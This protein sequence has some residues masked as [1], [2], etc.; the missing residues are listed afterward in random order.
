MTQ[1]KSGGACRP[2]VLD[3][4]A[5]HVRPTLGVL[6]CG[7]CL[8][9]PAF[10]L[11]TMGWLCKALR[12]G[13]APCY[14]LKEKRISHICEILDVLYPFGYLRRAYVHFLPYVDA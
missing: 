14:T 6:Y 2:F 13:A 8:P 12:C 5:R 11:C 7:R 10:A 9:V 1:H 3:V 4:V